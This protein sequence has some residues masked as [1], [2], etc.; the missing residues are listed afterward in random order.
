MKQKEQLQLS[1]YEVTT[2]V[3]NQLYKLR[4]KFASAFELIR[5]V[6]Q[7]GLFHGVVE[8]FGNGYGYREFREGEKIATRAYAE[9]GW[10]NPSFSCVQTRNRWRCQLGFG[11]HSLELTFSTKNGQ[12]T[13]INPDSVESQVCW[14]SE[15]KEGRIAEIRNLLTNEKGK[16]AE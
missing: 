10:N 1:E 13:E 8:D 9:Q 16:Y 2:R 3:V 12:I 11:V 6:E 7:F 4:R 14:D 5:A 15:T